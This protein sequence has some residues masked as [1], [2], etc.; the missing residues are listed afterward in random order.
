MNE[1]QQIRIEKLLFK[2]YES[3]VQGVECD[4]TTYAKEIGKALIIDGVSNRFN[5]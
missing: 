1:R 4:L 3:G 2:I 5:G